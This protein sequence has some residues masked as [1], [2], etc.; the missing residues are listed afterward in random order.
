MHWVTISQVDKKE[1]GVGLVEFS[2]IKLN[3]M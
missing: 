1:G 2:L 3:I